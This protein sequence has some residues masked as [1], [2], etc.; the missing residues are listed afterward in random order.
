MVTQTKMPNLPFVVGFVLGVAAHIL[1]TN[2]DRRFL[3][4]SLTPENT[5][6]RSVAMADN[7][8]ILTPPPI[9][10]AKISI[11]ACLSISAGLLMRSDDRL[12]MTTTRTL[13]R[14]DD[15]RPVNRYLPAKRSARPV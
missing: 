13:A 4:P 6:K 1:A 15:R 9:P 8:V 12:P 3:S 10:T 7:E 5:W 14:V 2:F 11:P